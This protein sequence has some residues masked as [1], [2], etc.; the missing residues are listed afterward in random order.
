MSC[1]NVTLTLRPEPNSGLEGRHNN[2]HSEF[3][4]V[5]LELASDLAGR[6]ADIFQADQTSVDLIEH[7]ELLDDSIATVLVLVEARIQ[8]ERKDDGIHR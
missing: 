6:G 8:L 3:Y 2:G 7:S 4:A 1:P 5:G